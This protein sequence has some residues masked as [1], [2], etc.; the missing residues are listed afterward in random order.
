MAPAS[1]SPNENGEG[2]G[3][4]EEAAASRKAWSLAYLSTLML[5][6]S[7]S[8][9]DTAADSTAHGQAESCRGPGS[10]LVPRPSSHHLH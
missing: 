5:L 8:T 1:S 2:K 4:R 10:S 7:E 3:L 6:S 9:V